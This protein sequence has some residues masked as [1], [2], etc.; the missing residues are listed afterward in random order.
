MFLN[1]FFY[2]MFF[3]QCYAPIRQCKRHIIPQ[4]AMVYLYE[5]SILIALRVRWNQSSDSDRNEK[6]GKLKKY[7]DWHSTFNIPTTSD[8]NEL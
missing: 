3:I 8:A 1:D 2:N 7:S 5:V 6:C 4:N